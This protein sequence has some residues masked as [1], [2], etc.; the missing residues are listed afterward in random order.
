MELLTHNQLPRLKI[1]RSGRFKGLQYVISG[2][3]QKTCSQSGFN[4]R[5]RNASNASLRKRDVPK[6]F[7]AREAILQHLEDLEDYY[8][9]ADTERY[10]GRVFTCEEAKRKLG[11]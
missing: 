5:S 11:L 8:L 10:P 4:P 3:F 1:I 2:S 6:T 9:A 7:Y